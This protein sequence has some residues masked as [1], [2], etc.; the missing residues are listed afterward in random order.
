LSKPKSLCDWSK[1][2]LKE[3]ARTLAA[4][5]R[6]A[7]HYCVKCARVS[8]DKRVLCKA[9]KLPSIDGSD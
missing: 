2:D 8:N 5:V 9:K 7:D 1:S 6:R 3:G 4:L